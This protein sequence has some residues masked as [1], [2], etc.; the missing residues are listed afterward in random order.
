VALAPDAFVL[1]FVL[2]IGDRPDLVALALV[3][4]RGLMLIAG[5]IAAASFLLAIS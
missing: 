5:G 2:A 3:I 1:A 4:G